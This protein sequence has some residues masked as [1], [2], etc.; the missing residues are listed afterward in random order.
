MVYGT[1]ITIVTGAYRPTYNWGG[2]TLWE[3]H[4]KKQQE[5][6]YNGNKW[7]LMLINGD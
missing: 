3:Y 1:Q 7:C 4:G 6:D 5:W 2:G